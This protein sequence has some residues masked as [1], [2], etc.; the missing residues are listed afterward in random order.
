VLTV[1]VLVWALPAG[2]S[3]MSFTAA[4]H[5]YFAVSSVDDVVV[6]G[7]SG[8]TYM[9]SLADGAEVVQGGPV[10]FDREVD[11]IYLGAPDAAIKVRAQTAAVCSA[12]T[13]LPCRSLM[14][15]VV[16]TANVLRTNALSACTA[17]M[18]VGDRSAAR[19]NAFQQQLSVCAGR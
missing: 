9:D 12:A 1:S 10:V 7:L 16:R 14:W 15:L 17:A 18:V 6:E 19:H 13:A 2:D 3:E 5:T 11:R 4:L 8:V